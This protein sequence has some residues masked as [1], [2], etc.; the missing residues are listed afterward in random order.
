MSRRISTHQLNLSDIPTYRV[1]ALQA[2]ANRALKKHGDELLKDYGITS[3]Q[4]HIIG[5]VLDAGE[6]GA[7]ISDLA[8]TLD[9]TLPFLTNNVN[10]L[11][12]KGLLCRTSHSK[13][14]R[15][16]MVKISDDFRPKC[17]EIENALRARLRESLYKQITP[18]ELRTY[19]QTLVKF[20]NVD[21]NKK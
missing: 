16:K 20:S 13:D 12:L 19:I 11:E 2:A 8:T 5:A 10:I 7:R 1:G 15:A 14:A 18:D 9:T 6:Q 3:M 21:E 4:W 17:A